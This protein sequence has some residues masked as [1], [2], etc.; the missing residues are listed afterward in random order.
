MAAGFHHSSSADKLS[1]ALPRGQFF[2]TLFSSH[3]S[4][5]AQCHLGELRHHAG[6]VINSTEAM[7]RPD[8]D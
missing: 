1:S 6:Q 2:P 3:E 5:I 4:C 7:T 8:R